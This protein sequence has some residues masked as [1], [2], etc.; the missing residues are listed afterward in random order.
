M[1][2]Y[3]VVLSRLTTLTRMI[4]HISGVN[5]FLFIYLFFRFAVVNPANTIFMLDLLQSNTTI[6][7][8]ETKYRIRSIPNIEYVH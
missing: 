8:K 5:Q 7:I 2:S 4:S 1:Y 3:T 6:I